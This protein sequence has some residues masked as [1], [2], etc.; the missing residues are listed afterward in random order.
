MPTSGNLDELL[1]DPPQNRLPDSMTAY[2]DGTSVR[3]KIYLGLAGGVAIAL[4]AGIAYA[5]HVAFELDNPTAHYTVAEGAEDEI[6][7]REF[8]WSNGYGWL[9]LSRAPPGVNKIVLPDRTIELADGFDTAQLKVN[10][11]DGKTVLLKVMTGDV[12]V[13]EL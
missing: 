13:T 8:V 2:R 12:Q 7:P 5:R 6:R 3:R 9:S 1:A 10:V 4:V 11:V